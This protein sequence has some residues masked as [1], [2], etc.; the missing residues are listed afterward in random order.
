MDMRFYAEKCGLKNAAQQL[1]ITAFYIYSTALYFLNNDD[2]GKLSTEK[3]K[4]IFC[5]FSLRSEPPRELSKQR[6]E[7]FYF[8]SRKILKF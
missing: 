8:W 5:S 2:E 1:W 4:I 6:K 3:R 7:R